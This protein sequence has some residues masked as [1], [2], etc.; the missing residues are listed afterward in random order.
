MVTDRLHIVKDVPHHIHVDPVTK[1]VSF[2][3]GGDWTMHCGLRMSEFQ[4]LKMFENFM[5]SGDMETCGRCIEKFDNSADGR[6]MSRDLGKL[7]YKKIMED[8]K[9]QLDNLM[10]DKG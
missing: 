7:G 1:E 3:G 6:A 9:Q 8:L 4:Y 2:E 10:G 5:E